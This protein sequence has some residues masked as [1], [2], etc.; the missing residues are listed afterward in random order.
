MIENLEFQSIC[1]L[2][3][4]IHYSLLCRFE[5]YITRERTLSNNITH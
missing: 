5:S 1:F 2:K 3:F 4:D